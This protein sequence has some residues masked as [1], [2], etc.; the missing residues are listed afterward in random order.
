MT[1]LCAALRALYPADRIV[2][3]TYSAKWNEQQHNLPRGAIH[4]VAGFSKVPVVLNAHQR[5][6]AKRLAK[7]IHP[8]DLILGFR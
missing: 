5:R 7:K 2:R 1:T 8:F 6:I 4:W 3:A